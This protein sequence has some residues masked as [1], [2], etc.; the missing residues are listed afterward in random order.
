MPMSNANRTA[1]AKLVRAGLACTESSPSPGFVYLIRSS[2]RVKIGSAR[3]EYGVRRQVTYAQTFNPR[4]LDGYRLIHGGLRV[5]KGLH[6]RLAGERVVFPGMGITG[7]GCFRSEWFEGPG[8][9]AVWASSAESI[10]PGCAATQSRPELVLER[11][12]A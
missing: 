4:G 12:L 6:A 9:E 5:E 11:R 3:G 7:K 2:G 8:T 1:G 10:C